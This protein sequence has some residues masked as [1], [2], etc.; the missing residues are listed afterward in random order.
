MGERTGQ[1]AIEIRNLI[2]G[3]AP[4]MRVLAG[5]MTAFADMVAVEEHP[6]AVM[7][8]EGRVTLLTDN[9]TRELHYQPEVNPETARFFARENKR[10]GGGFGDPGFRVWQGE[11]E[12]VIFTKRDLIR[13]ISSHSDGNSALTDAVRQLRVRQ[14]TTIDET[15]LDVDSD[16]VRRVE[17]ERT[18]TNIPKEF[19]LV[20]PIADGIMAEV[21][22]RAELFKPERSDYEY[23][24]DKVK[25]IAVRASNG[26]EVMRQVMLAALE[27]LPPAIPK[28]Y[29]SARM[30]TSSREMEWV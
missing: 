24:N 13:F 20:M 12:P 27:R 8:D 17:E 28:Y 11:Y 26:R 15:M 22:F 30:L 23:R 10:E 21:K 4:R 19:N 7:W 2:V 6:R 5:S 16:D 1:A 29:G 25:R 18:Q 3:A 14:S 9:P